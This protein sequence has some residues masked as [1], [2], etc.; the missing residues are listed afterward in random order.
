MFFFLNFRSHFFKLLPQIASVFSVTVYFRPRKK[1]PKAFLDR[2]KTAAKTQETRTL[3][4]AFMSLACLEINCQLVPLYYFFVWKKK[5]VL[6]VNVNTQNLKFAMRDRPHILASHWCENLHIDI[7]PVRR[8]LSGIL[9]SKLND[10]FYQ[11][12]YNYIASEF[13]SWSAI[14]HVVYE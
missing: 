1:L 11:Y 12:K 10:D 5:R 9:H 14:V 2:H 3:L 13:L 4:V 7:A 8:T 6:Y